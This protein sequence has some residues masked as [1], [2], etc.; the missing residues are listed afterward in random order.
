[1][2]RSHTVDYPFDTSQFT[3]HQFQSRSLLSVSFNV[4]WGWLRTHFVSFRDGV[5]NHGLSWVIVGIDIAYQ[6]R[7]DFFDDDG[8]TVEVKGAT[9]RKNG[10][11]L[12]FNIEFRTA[13]KQIAKV[14]ILL[15]ALKVAHLD[16]SLAGVTGKVEGSLLKKLRPDEI[17]D[18]TP[19][20]VVPVLLSEIETSGEIL[21]EGN[22]SLTIHRHLCEVADQWCFVELMGIVGRGR[23]NLVQ[24]NTDKG[25]S[26]LKGLSHPLKK[27]NAELKKAYF[28]F[29][30]C[31]VQTK[32]YQVGED[33][34]FV[35]N[36]SGENKKLHASVIEKF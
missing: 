14:K 30:E 11:L 25:D 20:R 23:E 17:D 18:T 19:D 2:P 29:D 10:T 3:P 9:L 4:M 27:I 21:A 22:I 35:H 26:L 8:F 1:M 12:D 31:Y 5:K 28:L 7:V 24:A 13:E 16:A 6:D 34:Y 36:L 15:F 32:A 33:V